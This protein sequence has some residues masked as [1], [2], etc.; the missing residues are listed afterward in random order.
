V[1]VTVDAPPILV[2]DV[3]SRGPLDG[4]QQKGV[5]TRSLGTGAAN[6]TMLNQ[7]AEFVASHEELRSAHDRM[8]VEIAEVRADRHRILGL[9]EHATAELDTIRINLGTVD[10][11]DV[12]LL[13][14]ELEKLNLEVRRLYDDKQSLLAD[15]SSREEFILQLENEILELLSMKA[16]C[17]RLAEKV[18][19]QESDLASVRAERGALADHLSEQS[20]ALV[21]AT[22]ELSRL[23]Q[24]LARNEEAVKSSHQDLDQVKHQLT[25]CKEDL[26]S[27]RADLRRLSGEQEGA[28]ETIERL[29]KTIAERDDTIQ[30]QSCHFV[31]ELESHRTARRAVERVRHDEVQTLKTEMTALNFR[32]RRLCENH[33]CAES[34]CAVL[35]AR[36]DELVAAQVRL[37]ADH[38]EHIVAE[39]VERQQLVEELLALRANAEETGRVAEELI[40]AALNARPAMQLVPAK[41]L[42]TAQV[43]AEDLECNLA[44]S[45]R[46]NRVMAE[47]LES[48]GIRVNL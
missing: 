35:Q 25:C 16:E 6:V 15:R 3:V 27:V 10:A 39:R 11:V 40:S 34:A 26:V 5:E 14:S 33:Q 1:P 9:F 20:A 36:N 46:L 30:A 47:T 19:G 44:E 2:R 13:V 41:E 23:R 32:Y 48:V 37:E 31:A 43:R 28:L 7:L 17:E 24:E 18:R 38:N 45:E 22:G 8:L 12:Q 42:A 4:P 21:A 29:T